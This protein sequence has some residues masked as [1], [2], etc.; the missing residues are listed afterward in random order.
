MV[1]MVELEFY[2]K[3]RV[4]FLPILNVTNKYDRE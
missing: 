1:E 2:A 4:Y 3:R